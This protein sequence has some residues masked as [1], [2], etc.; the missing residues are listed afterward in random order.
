MGQRKNT[1]QF[2]SCLCKPDFTI[3]NGNKCSLGLPARTWRFPQACKSFRVHG[4]GDVSQ[5]W[6]ESLPPPV[7]L[8][9]LLQKREKCAVNKMEQGE[10]SWDGLL[11][12]AL[13]NSI[14]FL[15]MPE[16]RGDLNHIT[17]LTFFTGDACVFFNF[18]ISYLSPSVWLVEMNEEHLEFPTEI[19]R[20]LL[21][22]GEI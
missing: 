14:F 6:G 18:W 9:Y 16:F 3:L 7:P 10:V 19:T 2:S 11:N 17:S 4:L 1:T 20:A 22:S 5:L 15:T 8:H 12:T 21:C 13:E